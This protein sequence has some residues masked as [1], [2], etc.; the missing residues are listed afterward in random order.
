MVMSLTKRE[1]LSEKIT[2]MVLLKITLSD[3]M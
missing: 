1:K 2:N 3:R